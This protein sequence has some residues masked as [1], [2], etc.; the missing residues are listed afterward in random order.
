MRSNL[1]KLL[2]NLTDENKIIAKHLIEELIF[3]QSTLKKLKETVKENGVVEVQHNGAL[4]NLKESPAIKSYNQT[5]KSYCTAF[6]QLEM[7]FQKNDRTNTGN[8]LKE[9]L[10]AANNDE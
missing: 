6:K 1:N 5:V 9:W 7:M 2:E 8:A 10:E 3:M 4:T